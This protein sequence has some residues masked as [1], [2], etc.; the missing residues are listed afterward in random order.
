[1]VGAEGA[2]LGG[3]FALT[4]PLCTSMMPHSKSSAPCCT[5]TMPLSMSKMPLPTSRLPRLI[6]NM[7][8]KKSFVLR[9]IS[10]MPLASDDVQ[11][12]IVDVEWGIVDVQRGTD[13][14]QRGTNGMQ[15][16]AP[17]ILWG[18]PE[19]HQEM[20][21]SLEIVAHSA[22]AWTAARVRNPERLSPWFLAYS[23]IR[24]SRRAGTVMLIFSARPRYRSTST[25]ITTQTAPAKSGLP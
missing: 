17:E 15:K 16:A 10:N 24:R 20:L 8:L 6:S 22:I 21:D 1:M 19:M 7:S 3:F 9:G 25:S 18:I 4:V 11:R 2:R 23:S 13:D 14:L 12:G 5:S